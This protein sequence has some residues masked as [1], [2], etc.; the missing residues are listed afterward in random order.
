MIK[1][2]NSEREEVFFNT[3]FLEFT[4]SSFIPSSIHEFDYPYLTVLIRK[5]MYKEFQKTLF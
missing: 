2:V 4:H 5:E 3:V 1:N